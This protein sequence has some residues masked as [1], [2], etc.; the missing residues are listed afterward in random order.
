MPMITERARAKV[1]LTLKILGRRSDGYHELESLVAFADVGDVVTLDSDAP[2]GVW[3]TGTFGG[4]I[5]GENL[6]RVTLDLLAAAEPQLRLGAI[7]LDKR[8]PVAAGIGG[9]S[10]DAAA[11][12]RA[13]RRANPDLADRVDWS[14]L[15]LKLGADVPVC[16]HN[17]AAIMRG[18]GEKLEP[19]DGLPPLCVILV[20]PQVPVPLDKT[21]RVF[22]MLGAKPLGALPSKN[23]QKSFETRTNLLKFMLET[24]NDLTPPALT[25]V[26]DASK[27]WMKLGCLD[28]VEYIEISGGGPTCFAVFPDDARAQAAAAQLQ[29]DFPDW[30]VV[31]TA[32]S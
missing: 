21:A 10:A 2:A 30:W 4:S 22:S 5:A 20:N 13:V 9:G 23:V 15:A 14:G 31:A 24:R 3:V 1:N 18:I 11:V 32:V 8:L 12:L 28:E 25:V 16:F 17:S 19:V 29:A 7:V 6:V 27:V 26:R